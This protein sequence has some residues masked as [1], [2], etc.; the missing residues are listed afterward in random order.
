[1]S[2]HPRVCPEDL[3][4]GRSPVHDQ[5]FSC[6]H[7]HTYPPVSGLGD[8]EILRLVGSGLMGTV[9]LGKHKPSSKLCAMKLLSKTTHSESS[10]RVERVM[11][12]RSLLTMSRHP[13]VAKAHW[14]FQT[15]EYL[16]LVM[17]YF[18]RGNLSSLQARQPQYI[19]SENCVRFYASQI[20][21][22]LEEIHSLGYS[23]RDIKSDNLVI[24][25]EG[26]VVVV[27]FGFSKPCLT[28]EFLYTL[29]KGFSPDTIR[30]S[31]VKALS[32]VGT[33]N[34][35]PPEVIKGELQTA[36]VDWWSL[37]VLLYQFMYGLTPFEGQDMDHTF[38][39]IKSGKVKFPDHLRPVPASSEAKDLLKKLLRTNHRKR[40]GATNGAKD[41][42]MHRFFEG[43]DW[44]MSGYMEHPPPYS[45]AIEPFLD[46]PTDANEHTFEE[47]DYSIFKLLLEQPEHPSLVILNSSAD[48]STWWESFNHNFIETVCD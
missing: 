11:N 37:G 17:D 4:W 1:M 15:E 44:T 19:F 34:F 18:P 28:P 31:N 24:S 12:E 36:T 48:S 23:Y 26:Y 10:K 43:V 7:A 8:F 3:P 33:E 30:L 40:L 16:V 45:L 29:D 47:R 41:L 2:R 20:V 32:F 22:A 14:C 42:K 46:M 21:L 35:V 13:F 25:S 27:D 6:Q 39:N 9:V 5:P 38:E